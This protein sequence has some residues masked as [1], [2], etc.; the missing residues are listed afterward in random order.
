MENVNYKID[1]IQKNNFVNLLKECKSI[2]D[3]Y[4]L[5]NQIVNN[6]RENMEFNINEY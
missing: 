2:G 1:Y 6:N 5:V 4:L 3:I